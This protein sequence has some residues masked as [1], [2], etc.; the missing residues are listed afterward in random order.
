MKNIKTNALEFLSDENIQLEI[1]FLYKI[2]FKIRNYLK[3][4]WSMDDFDWESYTIHYRAESDF[5]EKFFTTDLSTIDFKFNNGKIY[6]LGDCKPLNLTWRCIYEAIYNLPK[7]S[8]VAEIGIGE[9][10]LTANLR[11]I[12]GV[13]ITFTGYDISERQLHFFEEQ[14]PDVFSEE[15]TSVLD[16]TETHIPESVMPDLVF[17]STVLMHIHRPDAY[18]SALHNLLLSSRKYIV[19]MDNWNAH[20]YFLDLT[21]KLGQNNLYFYDSGS[22]IAIV[23]SLHGELLDSPYQPLHNGAQLGKYMKDYKY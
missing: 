12:L 20:D 23:I 15:A 22:S 4:F 18:Q 21:S 17:A 6:I 8:S 14:Y 13:D 11:T 7:F 1:P 3:R 19:L 10:L 5:L 16:L 2:Q 9:G